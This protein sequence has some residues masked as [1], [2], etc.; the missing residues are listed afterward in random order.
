MLSLTKPGF[1]RSVVLKRAGLKIGFISYECCIDGVEQLL[2]DEVLCIKKKADIIILLS[3]APF[4]SNIYIAEKLKIIDIILGGSDGVLPSDCNEFYLTSNTTIIHSRTN[5]SNLVVIN[6]TIIDQNLF[7]LTSENMDMDARAITLYHRSIFYSSIV[8]GLIGTIAEIA[9]I[10]IIYPC[11]TLSSRQQADVHGSG[12]L[13][14]GVVLTFLA[15]FLSTILYWYVYYFVIETIKL[16]HDYVFRTI[17]H[18]SYDAFLVHSSVYVFISSAIAGVVNVIL[19]NGY[20]V[21]IREL[22]DNCGMV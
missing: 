9:S 18:S 21:N 3:S 15:R 10:V 12:K 6:I 17:D 14:D 11:A 19:T 16:Y 7:A 1:L 2:I 5:G 20:T 8:H 13:Y 22:L 4:N